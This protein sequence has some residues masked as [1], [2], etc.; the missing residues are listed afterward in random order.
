VGVGFGVHVGVDAQGDA[1]PL[2]VTHGQALDVLQL[3]G[4]LDVEEQDAL[5]Q[6]RHQLVFGLAD[7]GEDYFF[8]IEPGF[9]RPIQLAARDDVRPRPEGGERTQNGDIAVRLDRVTNHVVQARECFFELPIG[10][11]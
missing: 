5:A 11:L 8:R 7:P 6:T 4:G 3:R 9:H 1:R 2:A 10:L